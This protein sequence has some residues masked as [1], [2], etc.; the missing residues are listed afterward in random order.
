MTDRAAGSDAEAT[1]VAFTNSRGTAASTRRAQARAEKMQEFMQSAGF[2]GPIQTVIE[3]GSTKLQSRGALVYV[4]PAGTSA[5]SVD[6]DSVRSLIVRL[7]KGRSITVDGK[8][9]GSDNVTG[10]IGDSMT[11]GPYLGLRMYRVDFAEPVSVA[12]AERVAKQ[13]SRDRGIEFAEPDSIVST[14]VSIA[15]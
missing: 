11:V 9:R 6:E 14:Q 12:V 5:A 10:P 2:T 13:L 8:V 7:K 1:I 4:Q 3:P 15:L